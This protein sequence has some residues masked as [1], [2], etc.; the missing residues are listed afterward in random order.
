MR[1]PGSLELPVIGQSLGFLH[2]MHTNNT[3]KWFQDRIKKYGP[4]SKLSLLGTPT[5]FIYGQAANKF[6]CT[7]DSNTLP[8]SNHHLSEESAVRGV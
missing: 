7:C 3:E 6:V 8:I 1:P 5:V 4:I 2:A